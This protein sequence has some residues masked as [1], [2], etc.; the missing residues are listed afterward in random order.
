MRPRGSFGEVALALSTAA[1]QPGTVRELAL[2]S[3]VGYD[4]ARYTASRLVDAGELVVVESGRPNKLAHR[5]VA[6]GGLVARALDTLDDAV[7]SF[8]ERE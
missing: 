4:V 1:M 6:G 7:R 3:C 5:D 2:R 8:W